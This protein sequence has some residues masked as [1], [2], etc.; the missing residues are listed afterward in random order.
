MSVG[1]APGPPEVIRSQTRSFTPSADVSEHLLRASQGGGGGRAGAKAQVL[2]RQEDLKQINETADQDKGREGSEVGDVPGRGLFQTLGP[3][4]AVAKLKME[5]NDGGRWP[6]ADATQRKQ[7]GQR[8]C[9]GNQLGES[10]QL[11]EGQSG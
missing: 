1:S 7:H 5:G 11:K 10:H 2:V 9:G 4:A 3:G 8:P 6:W